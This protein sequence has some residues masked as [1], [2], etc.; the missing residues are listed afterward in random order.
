MT[1]PDD[2]ED[3]YILEVDL[4]YRTELHKLHSD[5]PLAL[6][7]MKVTPNMLSPYCQQWLKNWTWAARPYL[8]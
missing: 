3:G 2:G 7:K 6:E 1:I 8:N 5:Y 4:E